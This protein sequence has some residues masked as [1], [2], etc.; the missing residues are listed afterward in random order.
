MKNVLLVTILSACSVA[1]IFAQETHRQ[2][3]EREMAYLKM[4]AQPQYGPAA[5]Q[6]LSHMAATANPA[7][8][9]AQQ[10]AVQ[11]AQSYANTVTPPPAQQRTAQHHINT[12]QGQNN[13]GE[14]LLSRAECRQ[15]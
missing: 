3:Q 11:A 15:Q 9:A 1:T 6:A 7:T 2:R 8:T 12:P 4:R 5:L 14:G 13:P 10:H